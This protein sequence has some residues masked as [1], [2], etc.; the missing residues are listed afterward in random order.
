MEQKHNHSNDPSATQPSKSD[1]TF[2]FKSGSDSSVKPTIDQTVSN[3]SKTKADDVADLSELEGIDQ[4][5]VDDEEKQAMN[6]LGVKEESPAKPEEEVES[7][8]ESEDEDEDEEEDMEEYDDEIDSSRYGKAL[9]SIGWKKDGDT[10]VM[11]VNDLPT[12]IKISGDKDSYFRISEAGTFV[13]EL[14]DTIKE[15]KKAA[16]ELLTEYIAKFNGDLEQA[17]EYCALGNIHAD[18]WEYWEKKFK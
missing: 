3:S 1:G 12:S 18:D 8:S 10:Y 5:L 2:T 15:A 11:H 17:A 13:E 16:V 4:F 9:K 14:Y 6:L 7:E